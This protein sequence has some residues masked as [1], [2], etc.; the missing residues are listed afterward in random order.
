MSVDEGYFN[1]T[2]STFE[3]LNIPITVKEVEDAI[4]RLKRNKASS[5]SDNE[6]NEY[7]I[8]TSDILIGHLVDMFNKFFE[9]GY[10]PEIW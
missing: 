10:F 9:A 8:E 6:F 1:V 5:P 4:K 7:F 2:N 3:E